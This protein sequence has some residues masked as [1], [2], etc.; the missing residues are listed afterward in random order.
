MRFLESYVRMM[1]E[2]TIK[3]ILANVNCDEKCEFLHAGDCNLKTLI[4][5]FLGAKSVF[6]MYLLAHL[7]PLLLF[8]LN[9]LK[10][11]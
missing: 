3:N 2:E 11:E 6:K 7:V 8:K 4:Q 10:K 9:K 1:D 5:F